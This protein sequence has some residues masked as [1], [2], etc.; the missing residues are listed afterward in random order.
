M[1]QPSD[2]RLAA[3]GK[4]LV[5]CAVGATLFWSS[6]FFCSVMFIAGGVITVLSLY[7]DHV[8]RQ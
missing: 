1:Q 2:D 5:I 3:H 4:V 8:N 7:C 6:M